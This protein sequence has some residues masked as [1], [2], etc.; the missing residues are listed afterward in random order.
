MNRTRFGLWSLTFLAALSLSCRAQIGWSLQND[1]SNSNNPMASGVWTLTNNGNAF[2]AQYL[3]N[4]PLPH[5]VY[6]WAVGA[7]S[8]SPGDATDQL[9]AWYQAID[10]V[11]TGYDYQAGDIY[12]HAPYTV[13]GYTSAVWTSPINGTVSVSGSIWHLLN[14][15]RTNDWAGVV[16]GKPVPITSGTV[17]DSGNSRASPVDFLSGSGGSAVLA[18]IAVVVNST[19]EF[20]LWQHV[21]SP[22]PTANGVM[23]NIVPIPEPAACAALAGLGALGLALRLRKR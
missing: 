18:S 6:A 4:D 22:Y 9:P 13:G 2:A 3:W 19:I 23:L 10:S 5:P 21:G 1:W 12:V 16:N 15:G 8:R 11:G 14:L 20:R 17:S 7:S